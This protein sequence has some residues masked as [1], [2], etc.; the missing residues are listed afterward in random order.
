MQDATPLAA[1]VV[2][3]LDGRGEVVGAGFLIGPGQVATCAHVVAAALGGS[4]EGSEPPVGRVRVDLPSLPPVHGHASDAVV[5]SWRPI[6][7]ATGAGDVAILDLAAAP[8]TVHV[9]PLYRPDRLWGH[10]FRVLGF[11]AGMQDGVWSSGE[12]RERQ[13]TQWLQMQGNPSSPPIARGFSGAPVWDEEIEAIVG[14]TVASDVRADSTT[15]YLV[16]IEDVLGVDPRLL[17]NPFR[18]LEPFGEEHAAVFYGRDAEIARLENLLDGQPLVAV[19]GRSGTGKSSL[20]RAGLLPRL[21]R[22]GVHILEPRLGATESSVTTVLD[23]V[24]GL[25]GEPPDQRVLVFV[26]QFEE[27]VGAAPVGAAE[28]MPV[29]DIFRRLVATVRNA[30]RLPDGVPSRQLLLTLRWE[31]MNELL[32]DDVAETFDHGTLSL[33]PMNRDQLRQAI[34][35]PAAHAPGLAFDPGLVERMLDD[36]VGEPGQLPLVESLLSQLWERREG[37]TLKAEAYEQRGGVQG[38]IARHAEESLWQLH[39]AGDDSEVRRLLTMLARPDDSGGFVR[40][41]ARLD[42]LAPEQRPIVEALARRRLLVVGRQ[43]DGTDV[44]ELAHQALIDHWPRFRDWLDQDRDFLGWRHELGARRLTWESTGRDDDALLRGVAL[45]RAEEWLQ[46][47]VDDVPDAER[48]FVEAS[49]RRARGEARRRR[50]LLSTL[51]VI[52]VSALLLGALFAYQRRV[53]RREHA[54]SDSRALAALSADTATVDPAWSIALALAAY[55]RHPTPEAESALFRHYAAHHT[56]DAVLSGARGEIVQVEASWDG[57]VVAARTSAG[58]ITTWTRQPG[59]PVEMR[60][61]PR[62]SVVDMAISADGRRMLLVHVQ[63]VEVYDLA[64][65][66]VLW[67]VPV[68]PIEVRALSVGSDGSVALRLVPPDNEDPGTVELWEPTDDGDARLVQRLVPETARAFEQIVGFGPE[69]GTLLLWDHVPGTQPRLLSWNT[70]TRELTTVTDNAGWAGT[71]TPEG[72][73]VMCRVLPSPQ[74]V[75]L[76]LRDGATRSFPL[77]SEA[78]CGSGGVRVDQRAEVFVSGEGIAMDLRTGQ[79]VGQFPPPDDGAILDGPVL[80]DGDQRFA[81]WSDGSAVLVTEVLTEDR[82][83]PATLL[84]EDQDEEP[85]NGWARPQMRSA[86]LLPNGEHILAISGDSARLVVARSQGRGEVVAQEARPMPRL[87]TDEVRLPV[88]HDGTLVADRVSP[89]TIQIRTLP[90]LDLVTEITTGPAAPADVRS[91]SGRLMRWDRIDRLLTFDGPRA[92]WWDTSSGELV[93]EL[94]VQAAGLVTDDQVDDY[95]VA[96]YIDPDLA[97]VGVRG[98][99]GI[100]IVQ[101]GTGRVVDAVDAGTDLLDV[102]FQPESRYLALIRQGSLIELWD[103]IDERRVLGPLRSIDPF[104]SF[105]RFLPGAGDFQVGN[106]GQLHWYQA[107]SAAPTRR[108]DLGPAL[109][110]IDA[111]ADGMVVLY[112]DRR[113]SGTVMPV[114]HIEPNIWRQTLCDVIDGRQFTADERASLPPDTPT[115][116]VC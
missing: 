23:R 64:A 84:R 53:T 14:M 110:P 115:H 94:D 105:A 63:S 95:F 17:P 62:G 46:R 30:P 39:L 13:G 51:S 38:A 33:A 106:H 49:R 27:L 15:A 73:A 9:P 7:P 2:R 35:G 57:R 18:G 103:R 25:A 104:E 52:A 28:P 98:A 16:P 22:R 24:A 91:L 1:S 6:D 37:G 79:V 36:A 20:V 55:E 4:P 72:V 99:A 75:R 86:Q 81:L 50:A 8:P 82:L 56:T 90:D 80:T 76:D 67:E 96:P 71:L 77:P 114:L 60:H 93:A 44:V 10:R 66:R 65:D 107:G 61:L 116:D 70:A 85:V 45:A 100:R 11:P 40:R 48:A 54:M 29:Q 92:R 26:D 58:T 87:P 97:A 32:T 3:V 47:R 113:V 34:V 42:E 109:H 74:V 78:D 19:L 41:P 5:R 31:A 111:S 101:I 88:N 69:P 102:R 59:Q 43:A 108:L 83:L 68:V 112:V 12:L 21:R 89:D